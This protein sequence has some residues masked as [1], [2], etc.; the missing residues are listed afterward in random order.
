MLS[1]IALS[2]AYPP[3]QTSAFVISQ[4][5]HAKWLYLLLPTK[6]SETI[7]ERTVKRKNKMSA[8]MQTFS[9]DTHIGDKGLDFS[10]I[11]IELRSVWE[12]QGQCLACYLNLR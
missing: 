2:L 8:N 11:T 12:G 4:V 9:M 3:L 5:P 1:G 10:E 6:K 7:R